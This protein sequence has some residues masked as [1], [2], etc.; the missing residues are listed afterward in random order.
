VCIHTAGTL[1]RVRTMLTNGRI[2]SPWARDATAMLVDGDRIAWIGDDATAES[3]SSNRQV[4]IET[5]LVVP[6][7]V[8][9]HAHVTATGL[10][11][12]GSDLV[13]VPTLAQALRVVEDRARRSGGRPLIASGWDELSW[14]EQRP[15][16][17]AELDRAAYGGVVYLVRTDAHSAIA[18]SA[19]MATVPGL[20][21]MDGYRRDGWLTK[22]AHH[23]VRS[24]AL[25]SIGVHERAALQRA[26][27]QHAASLGIAAVHEMGGPETSSA[28]DFVALLA[29]AAAE[30]LPQVFGYWGELHAVATALELGAVGA[31][32]DLFCD[33]SI[34]SHTAG[35][36]DAYHDLD[37]RGY[38]RYAT[39]ELAAHV[40][41][42]TRAGLQAGFHAIGDAAVAQVVEAMSRADAELGG[43]RVRSAGH[44][45]EHAELIPD[46][47]AFAASGIT[48]SMQPA[49]DATWGGRDGMYARR[50]GADRA[51][52]LNPFGPLAS[53]GVPLVFGSDTPVT[54][55]DPWAAIRAAVYPHEKSHAL[56]VRAAFGAHTRAGWRAARA[57]EDGSGVLQPGAPATY[58]I[59]HAGGLGVDA[60]DERVA[61]WSTDERAGVPGLPEL[62]P[63]RPTPRCVRTV[64]RG[65]IIFDSGE[66]R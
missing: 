8:D 31:G 57:D 61:R 5:C 66:L 16:T 12:T 20:D 26:T 9:G 21:R 64:L 36:M 2:H 30:P 35:L 47:G 43:S 19:L 28:E 25:A 15:P 22:Q 34:G 33:G 7:F 65:G 46:L 13:G 63:G 38:L 24:V 59:F 58:A 51:A 10:A 62:T 6:A 45:I 27:L 32:G 52:G 54:P 44:R 1:A 42:C 17:A 60:P 56:S 39:A 49:F 41:A 14:P 48:A 50:L 29:L 53:A 11:L 55:M 23:A 37:D 40:V 18:S 3:I 4:D